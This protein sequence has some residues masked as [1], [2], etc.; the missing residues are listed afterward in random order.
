[1]KAS[2]GKEGD[3]NKKSTSSTREV[4]EV[5][6]GVLVLSAEC[7]ESGYNIFLTEYIR[8]DVERWKE[9]LGTF[10]RKMW[11]LFP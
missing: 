7:S 2:L 10:F 8:I 6:S 11:N 3:M 5:L 4:G 1:M 9:S